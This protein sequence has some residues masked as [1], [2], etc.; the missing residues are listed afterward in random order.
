MS[1]KVG[2]KVVITG[3]RDKVGK[4]GIVTDIRGMVG[5]EPA[6]F[7]AVQMKRYTVLS[8]FKQSYLTKCK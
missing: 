4:I 5:G 7:V 6:A 8:F 3:G 1:L 2:D